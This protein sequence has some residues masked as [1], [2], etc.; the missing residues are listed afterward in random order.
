MCVDVERV[1]SARD[2]IRTVSFFFWVPTLAERREWEL[3]REPDELSEAA[4]VLCTVSW[5]GIS[6]DA[7]KSNKLLVQ[8]NES[9]LYKCSVKVLEGSV[10]LICECRSDWFVK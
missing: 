6:S 9:R 4:I 7:E 3:R 1:C 10:Y 2:S 8:R 5:K